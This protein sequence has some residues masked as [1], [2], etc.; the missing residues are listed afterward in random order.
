MRSRNAIH[1]LLQG[2]FSA[3]IDS[4]TL[5]GTSLIPKWKLD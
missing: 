2:T 5:P 3:Q 1:P 4:E